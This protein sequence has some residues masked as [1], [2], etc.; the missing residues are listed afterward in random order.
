MITSSAPG[1]SAR[2]STRATSSPSSPSFPPS[3]CVSVLRSFPVSGDPAAAQVT[4]IWSSDG[5]RLYAA[6]TMRNQIAEIDAD[7]GKVLRRIDVGK[8]G[9]GLA[10]TRVP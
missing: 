5:K 7:T 1:L 10:V 2:R 8:N 3:C 6:E 9:D 4:L